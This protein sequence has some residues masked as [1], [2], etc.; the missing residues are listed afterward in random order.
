V[1]FCDSSTHFFEA[2]HLGTAVVSVLTHAHHHTHV[3][4]QTYTYTQIE[5]CVLLDITRILRL[6]R[7]RVRRVPL[8]TPRVRGRA[9]KQSGGDCTPSWDKTPVWHPRLPILGFERGRAVWPLPEL[10]TE[11]R[12]RP[13]GHIIWVVELNLVVM[14]QWI[15]VLIV[16]LP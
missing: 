5:D 9:W 15:H 3:Y 11:L 8:V 4:K 1:L 6:H 14:L 16:Y 10:P 13:L 7:R 2:S 12:A